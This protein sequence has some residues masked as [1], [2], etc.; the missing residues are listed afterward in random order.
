M[1]SA[2]FPCRESAVKIKSSNVPKYFSISLL[3]SFR[4]SPFNDFITPSV[5]LQKSTST[6][7]EVAFLTYLARL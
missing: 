2:L 5:T 1:N 7:T 6:F 3:V 4:C